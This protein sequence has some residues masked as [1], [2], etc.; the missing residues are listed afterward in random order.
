MGIINTSGLFGNS[1]AGIQTGSQFSE[2][3]IK[4][5]DFI[6]TLSGNQTHTSNLSIYEYVHFHVSW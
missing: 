6:V 3:E 4:K 2:H 1:F 5:Q